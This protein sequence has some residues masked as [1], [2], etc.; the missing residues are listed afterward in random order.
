MSDRV[1]Y[2]I[3]ESRPHNVVSLRNC[4]GV[5]PAMVTKYGVAILAVIQGS[6]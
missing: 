3:A 5:G 6:A 1:L 4:Q 2:E